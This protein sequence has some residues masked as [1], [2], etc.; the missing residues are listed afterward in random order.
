MSFPHTV[1]QIYIT[2]EKT[3][4]V[5]VSPFVVIV[6]LLLVLGGF[7][8]RN[9]S[10]LKRWETVEIEVPFG[11]A[12][13]K[14]AP[15]NEIVRIAH[16]AWV[17]IVTRKVGLPFDDEN[18]VLIEVYDSWYALF[19][20]TRNLIRSVP[21]WNMRHSDDAGKLIDLLLTI[22]NDGMRPHLTEWQAKFRRWYSMQITLANNLT[23]DPQE[24][25]RDYPGYAELVADLKRINIHMMQFADSLKLIAQ[26]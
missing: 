15:N 13:V 6:F 4:G 21:S 8:W 22:M 25:Q 7:A 23:R 11:A 19:A 26:S 3:V 5:I 10:S 17:E 1:F 16:Q 12:K 18:D 9:R 2:P 20:E 24:I 14:I